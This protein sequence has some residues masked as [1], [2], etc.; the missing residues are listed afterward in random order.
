MLGSVAN[1]LHFKGNKKH[2]EHENVVA[3]YD[4]TPF[5]EKQGVVKLGEINMTP[6]QTQDL[7]VIS[8]LTAQEHTEENKAPVSASI[9]P[10]LM[11]LDRDVLAADERVCGVAAIVICLKWTL[12]CKFNGG[13]RE[14]IAINSFLEDT[15][16]YPFHAACVLRD[17][18]NFPH[19]LPWRVPARNQRANAPS[20]W[21]ARPPQKSSHS[22]APGPGPA[23]ASSTNTPRPITN[24]VRSRRNQRSR[25]PGCQC[26]LRNSPRASRLPRNLCPPRTQSLR[27]WVVQTV[28]LDHTRPR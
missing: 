16:R 26:L 22:R 5:E 8:A 3:S 12:K 25:R 23:P 28:I 27:V 13:A 1:L 20:H 2:G 17:L 24:N 21:P 9:P 11:V 7:I 14:Y 15:E 19:I 18:L 6:G 10:I 4:P